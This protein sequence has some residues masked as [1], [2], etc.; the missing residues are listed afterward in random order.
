M[1]ERDVT[2]EICGA[3]F[4]AV[5]PKR[6][7]SPECLADS[8]RGRGG[9]RPRRAYLLRLNT[10]ATWREIAEKVGYATDI[11]AVNSARRYAWYANRDWPIVR[12]GTP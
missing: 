1:K 12:K 2:C 11:V 9:D 5:Q 6:F 7:C 4:T 10:E 3:D 8:A